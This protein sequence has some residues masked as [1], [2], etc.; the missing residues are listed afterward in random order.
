MM[1]LATLFGVGGS[2]VLVTVVCAAVS[3]ALVA[4]MLAALDESG[5]APADAGRAR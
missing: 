5:L 2:D 3:A 4:R 1:P